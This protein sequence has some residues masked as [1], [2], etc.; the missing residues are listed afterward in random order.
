MNELQALGELLWMLVTHPNTGVLIALLVVAAVIDWRTMRIPNWLTVSGMVY[1]LAVNA[2]HATGIGAG[3]LHAT[4]GLA[5]GLALM[6]PL[7]LIRVL[8]A[9]DAKL[10]A[11]VGAFV[12][13]AAVFKAT[14]VV[15]IV[16]GVIALAWSARHHYLKRMTANAAAAVQAM[17]FAAMAG[18]RPTASLVGRPSVG[19]LPYGLSIAIGTIAWLVARQLGFA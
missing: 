1:G 10:M 19:K 18:I 13:P 11:M 15:F 16:G 6:L 8:G 3:L 12:G 2:L 7:Y 4:F 14:V 17:A 5:V 9:G